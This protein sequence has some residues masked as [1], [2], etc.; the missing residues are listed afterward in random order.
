[1]ETLRL[2]DVKIL[3]LIYFAAN[4]KCLETKDVYASC[5][6]FA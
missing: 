6:P 4:L 2:A 1:M 5:L 3:P